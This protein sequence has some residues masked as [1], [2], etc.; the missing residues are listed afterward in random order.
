[1]MEAARPQTH[2]HATHFAVCSQILLSYCEKAQTQSSERRVGRAPRRAQHFPPS[3]MADPAVQAL[4][5]E[6]LSGFTGGIFINGGSDGYT[7]AVEAARAN[8]NCSPASPAMVL[9]PASVADVKAAVSCAAEGDRRGLWGGAPPL[10]VCGG[11][12]SEM[13]VADRGITM[14]MKRMAT[15]EVDATSRT[16][17]LGGGATF[18]QAIEA[19]C[20]HGLV[21]PS[22]TA[23]SVGIGAVLCGGVGKLTRAFGLSCDNVLEADVVLADGTLRTVGD[24]QGSR[25]SLKLQ[26]TDDPLFWAMR[27]CGCQFGVV[28]RLVVRLFKV[29]GAHHFCGRTMLMG[30]PPNAPPSSALAVDKEAAVA[31]LVRAEISA[32]SLPSAQSV[33]LVLGVAPPK[34]DAPPGLMF[35]TM[36]C[37]LVG[38]G[39]DSQFIQRDQEALFFTAGYHTKGDG[40]AYWPIPFEPLTAPTPPLADAAGVAVQADDV[41]LQSSGAVSS[42]VRQIFVDE[43]AAGGWSLLVEHA[44]AC[45]SPLGS[46]VLQHGGG[47]G[48]RPSDGVENSSIGA[49]RW[50]YSVLFMALWEPGSSVQ[51]AE[52]ARAASEA[53]ADGGWQMLL[54]H[55]IATGTYSVDINPFRRPTTADREVAL[56]YGEH[57]GRLRELK[58]ELDP[59]NLFRAGWPLLPLSGDEQAASACNAS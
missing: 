36:P 51:E 34:A 45:P 39:L 55:R 7:D 8:N 25:N 40:P 42:Y 21:M 4:V 41:P 59:T 19:A 32:R 1:M 2:N 35:C 6:E 46:I 22:G 57:L 23:P 37:A 15:V 52:E 58:R 31:L 10:T 53:W 44:L 38:P 5:A 48:R 13:C 30:L 3:I 12:H 47:A 9:V 50:E 29:T 49:R 14:H 20:A 33:D 26:G 28:V 56:A 18:G 16:V 27:G 54:D 24:A 43:L 11:G 17:T